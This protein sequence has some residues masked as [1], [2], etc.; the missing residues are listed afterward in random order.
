M[1]QQTRESTAAEMAAG[2]AAGLDPRDVAEGVLSRIAE[3]EPVLNAFYLH[4]PEQV[5]TDAAA[6]AARWAAGTQLSAFDGVPVTVKENIPRAGH[7]VPAGTAIANPPLAA[8]N[9]PITDR[10]LEAG[11]LILG[12]TTMPDWGMLSSGVS[13]LHGISR[14]AWDPSLTTGGSSAGAGAAAAAGYGPLHVGTDIG[15]S[16]RLPGTWAGLAT[17]KPSAGLVPLH[18]P[19]MGRAAGPL[20]RTVADAQALMS[21]IARP[22]ARDYSARPYPAMDWEQVL[23]SPAGL[24]VGVQLD[25]GSGADVDPEIL[26]AVQRAADVFASAGATIVPVAPFMSPA[27]LAEIDAFWRTR[28]WADYSALDDQA[29]SQVLPYIARWCSGAKDYD[30]LATVRHY[31][32]F[33]EVQQVTRA[34]TE[35]FDLVLSPVAPM[36]AF[37]AEQEMPVNDPDLPM[38]HISF[39]LPYNMSGQP[40][41]TVNCGFTSDGRTIGL[42][43]SGRTGADDDVLAACAW[44]ETARGDAAP[45]WSLVQ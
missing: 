25:A 15:G 13:S 31:H 45:N 21:V 16:I 35:Q 12:S 33:A 37:A 40:A 17:L 9:A 24:R 28:S 3:R 8:S 38:A 20:T 42:Q 34:A 5:R 29:R 32:R 44:Y 14:N 18:A 23:E 41:A 1:T 19:Y 27:M 30:G 36:A 4:D 6:S 26:A 7:P 39:T 43:V 2:Y 22:D 10:L 11:L